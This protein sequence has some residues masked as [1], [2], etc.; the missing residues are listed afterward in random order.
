MKKAAIVIVVIVLVL[1]LIAGYFIGGLPVASK[2]MGSNQPVDL[3]IEISVDGAYQGL[4]ALG[5][6]TTVEKLQEIADNPDSFGTVQTTLTEEEASSLMALNNAPDF[7]ARLTQI[8][9]NDDGTM[10]SSGIIW[11]DKFPAFLA[12]N[13]V[14][15]EG[16]EKV[17]GY[18]GFMD[19]TTYYIKGTFSIS[20]N[21]VDLDMD[22]VKVGRISLPTGVIND[23]RGS[24]ENTI[25]NILTN[26]GYNIRSLYVSDGKVNVDMDQPLGSIVPWLHYVQS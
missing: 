19:S 16:I 26:N 7:P 4:D 13:G 3:G 22:S 20:N 21:N 17:M 6:P 9:F 11:L 1:Y 18:I 12:R 8:K 14:S 5:Q 23:N 10:E 2:I 24:V 15:S 25:S